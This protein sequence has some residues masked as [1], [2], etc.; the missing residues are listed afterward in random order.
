MIHWA[1]MFV[2]CGTSLQ[3]KWGDLNDSVSKSAYINAHNVGQA[4]KREAMVNTY[5]RKI[6]LLYDKWKKSVP[7]E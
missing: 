4:K 6:K 1:R 7:E 3:K 5:H 2:L